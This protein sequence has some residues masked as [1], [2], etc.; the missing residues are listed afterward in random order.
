MSSMEFARSKFQGAL[1]GCCFS[2]LLNLATD[3]RQPTLTQEGRSPDG[4]RAALRFA[5][6]R[7]IEII[8]SP[9]IV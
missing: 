3:Q 2:D 9:Q 7:L 4:D 8:G 1:G 6:L 5:A